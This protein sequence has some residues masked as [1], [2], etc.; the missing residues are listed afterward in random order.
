MVGEEDLSFVA[1]HPSESF[2]VAVNEREPGTAV[3]Y[4]TDPEAGDL[5]RLDRTETGGTGPCHVAIDP[6]GEYAVVRVRSFVR[7]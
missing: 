6:R 2:V 4:D 1:F 7:Q 5:A 3:A